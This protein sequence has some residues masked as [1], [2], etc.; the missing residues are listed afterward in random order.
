MLGAMGH[1]QAAETGLLL[2]MS[3]VW[4]RVATA[5]AIQTTKLGH[6]LGAN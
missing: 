6:V 1:Y 3:T 2:H 5:A 4:R